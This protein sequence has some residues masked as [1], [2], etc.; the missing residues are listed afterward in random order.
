MKD[1]VSLCRRYLLDTLGMNVTLSTLVDQGTLPFFLHDHYIFYNVR[2]LDE[3]FI[4]L[5]AKS[6]AKL[7]PAA[8]RKHV[9]LVNSKLNI[10]PVFLC[11]TISSFNRKRLIEYKVPFIIPENQMYLPDL[12]IDLREHFIKARTKPLSLA[13]AT[14][15]VVLYVLNQKITDPLTPKELTVKLGY[16]KMSMSRSISEIEAAELAK[17]ET[18]GNKRLVRFD[19][20]SRELWEKTLPYLKTPIKKI[21]W[22]KSM[23]DVSLFHEAGESTLARHSALTPPNQPVYAIGIGN[24]RKNRGN[25][26]VSKY[27]DEATCKVELWSYAPGLISKGNKVDPFSLYLSLRDVK[28]ER[29]ESALKQ[30]MEAIEW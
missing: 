9:G 8:I 13:P 30:M 1:I 11:A 10:K 25:F 27:S 16:S 6:H 21:R 19:K 4:V 18:D 23:E 17:V 2:L 28:D 5:A 29:V 22:L 7:T 14:Q 15:A 24:W 12:A 3:D 26:Q 20:N